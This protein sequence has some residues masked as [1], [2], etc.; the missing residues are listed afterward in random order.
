MRAAGQYEV[1]SAAA[2]L[3]TCEQTEP[4]AEGELALSCDRP[5]DPECRIDFFPPEARI[6][7]EV[8]K[9]KLVADAE[10]LYTG[11]RRAGG[12]ALLNAH[13]LVVFVAARAPCVTGEENRLVFV[14]RATLSVTRTATTSLCVDLLEKDPSGDGLVGLTRRPVQAVRLDAEGRLL[15]SRAV[16][17]LAPDPELESVA[18]GWHP[19]RRSAAVWIAIRGSRDQRPH[20]FVELRWSDLATV[21]AMVRP[22]ESSFPVAM[23]AGAFV[24]V[25]DD[26]D[27][28]R[29]FDRV[30]GDETAVVPLT[31]ASLT[32]RSYWAMMRLG[33][34]E[35]LLLFINSPRDSV[36][37]VEASGSFRRLVGNELTQSPYSAAPLPGHG[38]RLLVGAGHPSGMAE[39]VV[40]DPGA[41]YFL[42]GRVDLGVQDLPWGTTSDGLDP[43]VFILMR[44][45]THL[46]RVRALDAE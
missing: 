28:L 30:G 46:I 4:R 45:T 9:L 38:A 27:R 34:T 25:D 21:G 20:N 18:W 29:Y 42:P 35:R 22:G 37:L 26:T 32:N 39:L 23:T 6:P 10:E 5:N 7:L 24:M 19:S 44:D 13:E 36:S 14:D 31:G 41:G 40:F 15:A 12:L 43:Y 16:E 17:L 33:D 3:G 2:T 8:S 1:L 11:G